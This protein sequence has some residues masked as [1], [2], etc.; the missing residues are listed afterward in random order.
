[1]KKLMLWFKKLF[2]SHDYKKSGLIY[3]IDE[4]TEDNYMETDEEYTIE[5]S[6][7]IGARWVCKKCGKI[8]QHI[9]DK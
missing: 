9:L 2:C 7:L 6:I 5:P 3:L 4:Y 8:K 1:M